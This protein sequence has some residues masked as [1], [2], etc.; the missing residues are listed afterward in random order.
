[1]NSSNP[2]NYLVIAMVATTL[3]SCSALR[4]DRSA[5]VGEILSPI[6]A[7]GG[8]QKDAEERLKALA[9]SPN[10]MLPGGAS[11]VPAT[12][13]APVATE[14][15]LSIEPEPSAPDS[16]ISWSANGFNPRAIHIGDVFTDNAGPILN[17]SASVMETVSTDQ[18][19]K[20][21]EQ[22][23]S[24][25]TTRVPVTLSPVEIAA[26]QE[27]VGPEVSFPTRSVA[28]D[29]KTTTRTSNRSKLEK[30]LS[31][32]AAGNAPSTM[33]DAETSQLESQ[34]KDVKERLKNGERFFV[35]TGVTE[36][37]SLIGT[38]PGAPVGS[39]DADLI[40]NAIGALYPHLDQLEAQKAGDVIEISRPP[41]VYW[42][43]EARELKLAGERLTIDAQS[44]AQN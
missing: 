31:G 6:E 20:W 40:R 22:I 25:K 5:D 24:A 27:Q 34:F 12:S 36:S 2:L 16:I 18:G 19:E 38:Y 11:V 9:N 29:F 4:K 3:S 44:L 14:A 26:L 41:R 28:I 17:K 33:A 21:L 7:A 13:E 15:P 10:S 8:S 42:E 39:R 43:F 30:Q 35:I 32:L 23:S 1:M 37:N